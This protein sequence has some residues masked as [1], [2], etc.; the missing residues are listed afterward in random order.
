[1]KFRN[2]KTSRYFDNLLEAV[3]S[4]CNK[5]ICDMCL[6]HSG[7]KCKMEYVKENVEEVAEIIGCEIIEEDSNEEK[8]YNYLR[9]CELQ[10]RAD[11]AEK[12]DELEWLAPYCNTVEDI[13]A[14][15][16]EIGFRVKTIVDE[17][18][19]DGRRYQWVET[20]SGIIVYV[21]DYLKGAFAKTY[22]IKN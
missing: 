18:Y 20:T 5:N 22:K 14:Y 3:D 11:H 16:R 10:Y 15:L 2:K 21:N 12:P 7:V 8:L 6:L 4:F 17:T 1:M 19:S 9:K 13:T